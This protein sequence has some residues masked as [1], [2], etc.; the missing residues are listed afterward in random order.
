MV[1]FFWR[2]PSGRAI[3]YKAIGNFPNACGIRRLFAA[4]PHA[5]MPQEE[6]ARWSE[7]FDH[8]STHPKGQA[9]DYAPDDYCLAINYS[10][11]AIECGAFISVG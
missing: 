10:P 6:R 5:G 11:G 2:A 3:R 9:A 1:F 4:V 7:S 8:G